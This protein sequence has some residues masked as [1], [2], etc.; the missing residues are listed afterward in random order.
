M[1]IQ[2]IKNYALQNYRITKTD[3]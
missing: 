1:K 3:I 2:Q